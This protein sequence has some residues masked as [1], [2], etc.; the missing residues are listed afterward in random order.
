M[1]RTERWAGAIDSIGSH[2]LANV[3]AQTRYG[4]TIAACGLA[5]GLDLPTS[6]A[7]FILRGVSLLGINANSPMPLREVV[8]KKM[9]N[10]YRPAHLAQIAHVIGLA[11]LNGTPNARMLGSSLGLTV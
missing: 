2:T 9:A 1:S 8:W 7:P 6:V 11:A 4:G 3:L 5:Q 10:E